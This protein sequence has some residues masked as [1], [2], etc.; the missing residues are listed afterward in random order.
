MQS[1]EVAAIEIEKFI[2]AKK[3]LQWG[4]DL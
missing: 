2:I 1:A 3:H 4:N